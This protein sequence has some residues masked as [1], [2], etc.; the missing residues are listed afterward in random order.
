MLAPDLG[1]AGGYKGLT[2]ENSYFANMMVNGQLTE[3]VQNSDGSE[4]QLAAV[5]VPY[6]GVMTL[7]YKS[8]GESG[9]Y[10]VPSLVTEYG[11]QGETSQRDISIDQAT[12]LFR[13]ELFPQAPITFNALSTMV[14]I[15]VF[16]P[17]SPVR[18]NLYA[19]KF[20]HCNV[21]PGLK[22]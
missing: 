17:N 19:N 20:W 5:F 9:I 11:S 1:D 4:Y 10:V 16:A 3:R 2:V 7:A 21:N 14:P 6:S 12:Q 13:A 15:L 8:L 22:R 18:P